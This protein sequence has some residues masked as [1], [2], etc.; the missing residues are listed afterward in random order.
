L[1]CSTAR[2][3]RAAADGV[4]PLVVAEY[5]WRGWDVVRVEQGKLDVTA[6]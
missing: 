3:A 4:K 2:N 5:T 6:Y 1:R